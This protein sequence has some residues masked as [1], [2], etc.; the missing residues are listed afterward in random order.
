LR[1]ASSVSCA[2]PCRENYRQERVLS[3]LIIGLTGDAGSGKSTVSKILAGLGAEVIDADDIARKLTAPGTPLLRRIAQSFGPAYLNADGSLNRTQLAK[4][5]FSNP[6]A[7]RKLNRLTHPAILKAI[8]KEIRAARSRPGVMVIEAPLLIETGLDRYVDE[9]WVV[10]A[11]ENV[12]I[13]RLLARGLNLE[14]ARGMLKSQLPQEEKSKQ[15]H[16]IIDNSGSLT[17]LRDRVIKTWMMLH[18]E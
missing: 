9:V 17:A 14:T 8:K 7:R 1:S 6:D 12:K 18:P 16:R 15:A 13:E 2:V 5:V 4:L 10:T 11:P 3:L